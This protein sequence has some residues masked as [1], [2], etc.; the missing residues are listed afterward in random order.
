MA[1]QGLVERSAVLNL[2]PS[3]PDVSI[4]LREDQTLASIAACKGKRDAL[5]AV[6]EEKYDIKLP[7]T[8][9]RIE[10]NGIAVIWSGPDQWTAMA[11]RGNG[12]DLE[13]ELK[14][15]LAGVA[16]VT[17]QSDARTI[18]R[19]SGKRSRAVLAK[20]VP[21][22]LHPRAFAQYGV[23][24]THASHIGVILWQLDAAPTFELAVFRSFAQS[25]VD[26]LEESAR[27]TA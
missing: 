17:D 15:L 7:A 11:P 2:K 9:E 19:I 12:R 10:G 23:A 24:I 25:L 13:R 14:P 1:S 22:D 27:S 20:G 21:I 26:W 6:F 8:P 4:S 18:V 5:I 16:S 3:F